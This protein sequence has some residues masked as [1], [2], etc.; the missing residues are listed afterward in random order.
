MA[1]AFDNATDGGNATATSLTFSHT[2]G[3][4]SS[5]VLLV[6]FNGD[7]IGG[8][9]DITGVTYGGVSMSPLAKVTV[10]A[11]GDRITYMYG[12][13]APATGANNVI[14]SASS[15]H[16]LQGGASSYTGAKQTGLPDATNTNVSSAGATSLDT[17]VTTVADNAWIVLVENCYNFGEAPIAGAGTQRRVFDGTNGGWGLFDSNGPFTPAGSHSIGTTRSSNPFNLAIIHVAVSIAPDT[18][19]GAVIGRRSHPFGVAHGISKGMWSG[20]R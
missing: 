1:I 6:G 3:S 19:G 7:S 17:S 14:I 11:S 9:D 10:A 18:G 12:L 2:C 15:S 13:I 8:A 20:K 16:V 5:R 4:G